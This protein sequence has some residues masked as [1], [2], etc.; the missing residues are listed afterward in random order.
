MELSHAGAEMPS[1]ES[2]RDHSFGWQRLRLVDSL[3]ADD[4]G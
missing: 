2:A 1:A 4:A 3:T